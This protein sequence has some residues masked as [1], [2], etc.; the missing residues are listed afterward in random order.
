MQ[1]GRMEERNG[2]KEWKEWMNKRRRKVGSL[3]NLLIDWL[4][5]LFVD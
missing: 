2:R 4:V 1:E 5:G 3:F